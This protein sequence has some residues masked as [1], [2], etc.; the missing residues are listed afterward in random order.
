M[1]C[2]HVSAHTLIHS[3]VRAHAHA[4]THSPTHMHTC[5]RQRAGMQTYACAGAQSTSQSARPGAAREL[6]WLKDIS[7]PRTVLSAIPAS[8]LGPHHRPV[9]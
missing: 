4:G 9:W 5:T 8:S 6:R 7:P 3:H 1:M 2:K